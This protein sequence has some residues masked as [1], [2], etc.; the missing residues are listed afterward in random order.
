MY[1]SLSFFPFRGLFNYFLIRPNHINSVFSK[2][3]PRPCVL[4]IYFRSI[5][6]SLIYASHQLLLSGLLRAIVSG[7]YISYKPSYSPHLGLPIHLSLSIAIYLGIVSSTFPMSIHP[8]AIISFRSIVFLLML[9]QGKR[10]VTWSSSFSNP[11]LFFTDLP[12]H[13][14]S[15]LPAR[16]LSSNLTYDLVN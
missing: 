8:V 6:C 5:R 4:N 10:P 9:S 13:Y 1:R 12:F 3:I 11:L 14:Y 16:I 15:Y 2:L 7:V